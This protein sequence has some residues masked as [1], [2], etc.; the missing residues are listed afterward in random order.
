MLL[1]CNK[2][3]PILHF[4][5]FRI[6]LPVIKYRTYYNYEC[7]PICPRCHKCLEREYLHF[8]YHCGQKLTWHK[9]QY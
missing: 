6:P 5:F 2:T 1:K 4:L 8:C 3:K 7:Y 9:Y